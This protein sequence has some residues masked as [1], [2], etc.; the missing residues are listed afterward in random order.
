M[1][2][3]AQVS[4]MSGVHRAPLLL[5]PSDR[6][7]RAAS[8]ERA[9]SAVVAA[10]LTLSEIKRAAKQ[11]GVC[12]DGII[13]TPGGQCKIG[14]LVSGAS[15]LDMDGHVKQVVAL[16]AV[17][18]ISGAIELTLDFE[19]CKSKLRMLH[20][21]RL[22]FS[23]WLFAHLF[24]CSSVTFPAWKL[25]IRLSSLVCTKT[26]GAFVTLLL[27]EPAVVLVNGFPVHFGSP[28][29]LLAATRK[30]VVQPSDF[31][32][33]QLAKEEGCAPDLCPRLLT[34]RQVMSIR[35]TLMLQHIGGTE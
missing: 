7:D 23:H 30:G 11:L 5:R 1:S 33:P 28:L 22:A 24:G 27:N 26:E 13:M 17:S 32:I 4:P 3:K 35:G 34:R 21:T 20:G 2:I 29:R 15:I 9:R 8:P 6:V 12:T 16:R 18:S 19:G 10:D 25:P 14:S 31:V